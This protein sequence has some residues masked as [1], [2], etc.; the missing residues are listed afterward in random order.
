MALQTQAKIVI[1]M[2]LYSRSFMLFTFKHFSYI[3]IYNNDICI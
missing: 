3:F 1:F 2:V